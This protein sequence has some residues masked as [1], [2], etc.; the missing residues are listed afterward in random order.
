MPGGES[1]LPDWLLR[2]SG[3]AGQVVGPIYLD[4]S[5][6]TGKPHPGDFDACWDTTGVDRNKLDSVFLDFKNGRANQKTA[7][8]GEFFPSAM[9]CADIGET[10][11]EFFQIERFTGNKKGIVSIS[12]LADPFLLSKVQP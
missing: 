3:F 5:Y 10:F 12:L 2:L 4:G 6:V 8:K 9:N 1:F 11:L 7:F